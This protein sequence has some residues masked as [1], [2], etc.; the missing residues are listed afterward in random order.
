MTER[1]APLL[2]LREVTAI[3]GVSRSTIYRLISIGQF[4]APIRIGVRASAWSTNEIAGWLDG[5]IA[6]RNAKA[7]GASAGE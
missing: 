2:R 7:A 3:T 1:V 4:P 6:E 5:R